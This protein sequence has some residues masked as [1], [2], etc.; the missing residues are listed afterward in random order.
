MHSRTCTLISL[1]QSMMLARKTAEGRAGGRGGGGAASSEGGGTVSAGGDN[2]D[3]DDGEKGEG[4][5]DNAADQAAKSEPGEHEADA[6]GAGDDSPSSR[7]CTLPNSHVMAG[8][9]AV[10][11]SVRLPPR[12]RPHLARIPTAPCRQVRGSLLYVANAGDSRAVI[13]TAGRAP[14]E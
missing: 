4:T 11:A 5:S 7:V 8:C 12:P 6:G 13:C 14:Y 3:D 9:T 2:D 1:A 10:V